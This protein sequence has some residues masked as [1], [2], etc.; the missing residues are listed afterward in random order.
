MLAL[1]ENVFYARMSLMVPHRGDRP[2]RGHGRD[3]RDL[4]PAGPAGLFR[5]AP[6]RKKGWARDIVRNA[7][8]SLIW[9][10]ALL[11]LRCGQQGLELVSL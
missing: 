1:L 10:A 4:F 11:R 7:G 3:Q 6:L 2:H 5:R 8:G 9:G